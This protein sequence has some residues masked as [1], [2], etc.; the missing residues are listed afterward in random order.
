MWNSQV[1]KE[2][3]YLGVQLEPFLRLPPDV[4]YRK[5]PLKLTNVDYHF[6]LSPHDPCDADTRLVFISYSVASRFTMRETIRSTWASVTRQGLWP[7]SNASYPGIEVFF[8]LALSE[9]PI[10]K[11]SAESDRYN[12]I[13]LAD[14]IDSYRNLTLKSLMT[15]KWMNEHCKLAHFMVK[16]D[17]DIFVNI[18]RMWSLLERNSMPGS[19][20]GRAMDAKVLRART[21]KF[22]VPVA[23][24]PFSQ[25]PQYLSGPIYAISAPLIP[26]LMEVAE[27]V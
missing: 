8:M 7:G 10:S 23:Q 3:A 14:F 19:M 18:P 4:Y 11:V 2:N 1:R 27:Y 6:L 26:R 9:V 22:S 12:D 20:I 13:I 24:Y 5:W 17:E 21:S 15:L 25:Y 16:V